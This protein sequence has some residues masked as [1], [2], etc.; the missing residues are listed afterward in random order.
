MT[1]LNSVFLRVQ[2]GV[3]PPAWASLRRVQAFEVSASKLTGSIP[4]I[5][6]SGPDGQCSLRMN[7]FDA[8]MSMCPRGCACD[9][10][11]APQPAPTLPVLTLP[12]VPTSPPPTTT[13]PT[14]TVD[15]VAALA[16]HITTTVAIAATVIVVV[17]VV[18]AAVCF[19]LLKRHSAPQQAPFHEPSVPHEQPPNNYGTLGQIHASSGQ[20]EFVSA[21]N[22]HYQRQQQHDGRYVGF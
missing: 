3:L 11:I 5:Q 18:V 20:N 2:G 19:L 9:N 10:D 12:P 17:V 21:R 1:S 7:E 16:D 15:V 14:L 22:D 4:L 6:F 8:T 13:A